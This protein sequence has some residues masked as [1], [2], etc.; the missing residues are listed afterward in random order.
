M[1]GQELGGA[2]GEPGAG[3]AVG[4]DVPAVPEVVPQ[5]EGMAQ[6]M[7]DR[8]PGE[9]A[10]NHQGAEGL[11]IPV[12]REGQAARPPG[13]GGQRMRAEVDDHNLDGTS[14][15]GFPDLPERATVFDVVP[16]GMLSVHAVH[17][18]LPPVVGLEA[19]GQVSV[20]MPPHLLGEEGLGSEDG[21]LHRV[22]H[23]GAEGPVTGPEVDQ[24][25]GARLI[26]RESSGLGRVGRLALRGRDDPAV[27]HLLRVRWRSGSIGGWHRSQ[28]E[29]GQGK[30]DQ[31][32]SHEGRKVGVCRTAARGF[33]LVDCPEPGAASRQGR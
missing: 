5:A 16:V 20:A 27:G 3:A 15:Q 28:E 33:S 22:H 13:E 21:R 10:G 24:A 25:H 12:L 8:S 2:G 18:R 29:A 26:G 23:L 19:E 9:R 17:Q 1:D 11:A 14:S 31:R 32:M 30:A 4:H 6:L 7:G